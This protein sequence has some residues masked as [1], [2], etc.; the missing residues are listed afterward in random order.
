M[1]HCNGWTYT[2][3]VTAAGGD[4]R[5]PAHASSRP[6]CSPRSRDLGVTHL[7]G[8]PIVLNMLIHA[9]DDVKRRPVRPRRRRRDRRCC[10]AVA[11]HRG[12][13]G[14][15]LSR[16]ASV[17]PHRIVRPG[18]ALRVAGRVGDARRRAS[19]RRRCRG[20]ASRCRRWTARRWAIAESGVPVPRDGS[21]MGEVMLR[22]NTIMKGYLK[23]PRRDGATRFAAAG[24]TRAISASGTRTTTSRSRTAPRTSSSPA[25]RT[26][27][28]W[29][30]R[31]ASTAIRRSI[32]AAVV[33]RPDA[34]WGESPCAFVTLKP[35]AARRRCRGA[36]RV[37]PRAS[38]ALQGAADRRVRRAAEDIDRQDPEVRAA[39]SARAARHTLTMF[40]PDLLA[41]SPRS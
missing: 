18:N 10:A 11:G 17:R 4:A 29:K 25:A 41:G 14:D 20:K 27:A 1:F 5:V 33:A 38:R 7:C 32:E 16:D 2:W 39:R 37:V 24:I 35:D 8:A 19:A 3:A 36:D 12:D 34:H 13:G 21:T 6:R 30:S 28:R 23:N 26:S 40:A 22:G 31:S 15:G 9:P